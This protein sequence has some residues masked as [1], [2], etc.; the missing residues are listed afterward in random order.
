MPW[1]KSLCEAVRRGRG[2]RGG[3]VAR[4]RLISKWI[5][6]DCPTNHPKTQYCDNYLFCSQ[7]TGFRQ[8]I[9]APKSFIVQAVQWGT[10]GFTFKVAHSW[11]WQ[12]GAGWW[13]AG[14]QPGVW[15]GGG[16]C[17]VL[18]PLHML[19]PTHGGWIP[20][21]RLQDRMAFSCG[22]LGSHRASSPL[23][24][25]GRGCIRL[26]LALE[27]GPQALP[28]GQECGEGRPWGGKPHGRRL[29][30]TGR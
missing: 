3:F 22:S 17:W 28:L 23:S 6:C 7:S 29:G 30:R 14:S 4:G 25:T 12:V 16:G 27:E 8:L 11:G 24:P 26:D 13:S 15:L 20:R 18:V 9:S 19:A 10:T 5:I 2:T 1:W 21:L